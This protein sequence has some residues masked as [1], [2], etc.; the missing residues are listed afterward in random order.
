MQTFVNILYASIALHLVKNTNCLI[1]A[2]KCIKLINIFK[3][4]VIVIQVDE[5][6]IPGYFTLEKLLPPLIEILMKDE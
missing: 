1:F 6:D 3:L 2:L 4:I 5:A